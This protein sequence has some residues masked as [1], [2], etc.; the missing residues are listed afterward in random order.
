[1]DPLSD[2][3]SL[4]NVRGALSV[5]LAAGGDWCLQFPADDSIRF[6][7]VSHG[8]C[9]LLAEGDVQGHTG[10]LRLQAG[11]CYVLT[12]G[13]SYKLGSDL[14]LPAL[15]LR[16]ASA[17]MAPTAGGLLQL[18]GRPDVQLSGGRFLLDAR[19]AAF[20][21]DSLAPLLHIK[22]D[23]EQADL[24]AW[25]VRRL[26]QEQAGGEPG[27]AAMVADLSHMLLV[28]TLRACLQSG[29]GLRPG[30]GWLAALPD[31]RIGAALGLM[32]GAPLRRWTLDS[33]AQAAGMSRSAFAL[34]FKTLVGSSPLDYL[35]R[36]KIRLA[37]QALADGKMSVSALGAAYGYL[38]DSAFSAAFKR[39]MGCAPTQYRA[40]IAESGMDGAASHP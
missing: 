36:W 27:T 10:A 28:Q 24:L 31:A 16:D 39:V 23:A 21:L 14:T 34:R 9:W 2:V 19:N 17:Y 13:R 18:G 8:A 5:R 33:L 3:L 30:A 35:L 15:A 22:S 6:G 20:L 11:D 29:Q 7:T 32:H 1:M 26:A 4:L 40:R 25:V 37:A 38:S 12:D